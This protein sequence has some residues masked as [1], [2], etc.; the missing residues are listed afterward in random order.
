MRRI[1]NRK[2]DIKRL[3]P[4]IPGIFTFGN[5]FCGFFAIIHSMGPKP[6]SAAWF[7]FLGAFLDLLDGKVAR[8]TKGASRIGV[9]LDSLADFTT[10]GIA[11]VAMLYA[12]G[13]FDMFGWKLAVGILYIFAGAFRLA[14]FNVAAESG[15]DDFFYGLPIPVAAVTIA[16]GLVFIDKVWPPIMGNGVLGGIAVLAWLMISQVKYPKH[17]P[18]IDFSNRWNFLILIPLLSIILALILFPVYTIYPLMVLFVLH[19]LIRE[20]IVTLSRETRGTGR[21]DDN[22]EEIPFESDG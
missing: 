15:R 10:F 13:L 16:S 3:T 21:K 17:P 4:V 7:I 1:G 12:V 2:M 11:P 19:G 8:M 18:R 5:L 6:L 22:D 20:V 9:Q 14:R